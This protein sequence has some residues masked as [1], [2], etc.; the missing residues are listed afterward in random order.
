MYYVED[1]SIAI[2]QN[3][4]ANAG[5]SGGMFFRRSHAYKDNGQAYVAQDLVVGKPFKLLGRT[6][7]I[8][9]CD[10]HT[11]QYYQRELD[12]NQPAKASYPPGTDEEL[13]AEHTTGMG[14]TSP[15]SVS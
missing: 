11:R 8:V 13:G 5:F 10:K 15:R 14:Q 12:I 3:D 7:H 1:G 2:Y 9:D 6:H 4:Q